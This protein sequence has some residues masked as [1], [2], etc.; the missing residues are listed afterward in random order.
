[1]MRSLRHDVDE[2]QAWFTAS[3]TR[4]ATGARLRR[5]CCA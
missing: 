5:R 2:A 1:M 3:S 4:A